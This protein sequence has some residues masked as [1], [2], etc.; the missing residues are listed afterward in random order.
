MFVRKL[1]ISNLVTRKVRAGLTIAAVALSV[2]LVVSVTTGYSS[3]LGAV[4]KYVEK[5]LGSIDAQVSRTNDP[6]GPVSAK[7]VDALRADPAV[8]RADGR[9]EIATPLTHA[10]G[11][12]ADGRMATVIGVD[13]PRD[14]R[15]ETLRV[16]EGAFFDTP[17]GD[18]VVIDQA[19]PSR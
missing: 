7:V 8:R 14:T 1:V 5:Y 9:A 4:N 16:R 18:V 10:D 11:K 3:V 17:D 15:I 13:R 12:A 6:R 2:S 19:W